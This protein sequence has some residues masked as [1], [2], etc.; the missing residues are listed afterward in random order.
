MLGAVTAIGLRESKKEATREA[1][2][3]AALRLAV[4]HGL[5]NVH[6]DDIAAEAGVSARTFN[7]YFGS[8]Q[9]AICSR[10]VD[11]ATRVAAA[12][13]ARPAGE[14]LIEAITAAVLEAHAP[15]ETEQPPAPDRMAGLRLVI[16]SGALQAE[17]L[18]VQYSAQR[19]IAEAIA[20]RTGSQTPGDMFPAVL[21]GAVTAASN[22]A[23]A[24]WV[25][26]DPPVP[27]APLLRQ[28]L[29]YLAHITVPATE[30]TP[31]C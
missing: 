7:N 23:F 21:A 8:K 22:T 17:Y 2:S 30:G 29:G 5:D 28:A 12:L 19:A 31:S 15:P 13:R 20:E 27:L 26:A 14:P 9:E 4:Q 3:G 18:R 1:L 16:G 10:I 6:V 24:R 25:M 11:R